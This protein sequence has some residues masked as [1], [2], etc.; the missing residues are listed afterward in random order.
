L[1]TRLCIE[2]KS[3]NH[4]IIIYAMKHPVSSALLYGSNNFMELCGLLVGSAAAWLNKNSTININMNLRLFLP[5]QILA[6][7]GGAELGSRS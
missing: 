1:A 2:Q 3:N 7:G 5:F 4:G 6:N